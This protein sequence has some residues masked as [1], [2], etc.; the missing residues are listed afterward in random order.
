MNGKEYGVRDV[1]LVPDRKNEPKFRE[2]KK[3]LIR[4]FS[5]IKPEKRQQDLCS[6]LILE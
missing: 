3:R 2:Q 1:C 4:I 6:D 5:E